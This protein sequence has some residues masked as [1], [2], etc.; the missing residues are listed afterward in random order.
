MPI[1][2]SGVGKSQS[3][4]SKLAERYIQTYFSGILQHEYYISAK[5]NSLDI[6]VPL[7]GK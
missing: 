4:A 3:G 5:D 6:Y 1:D 7:E 2:Q